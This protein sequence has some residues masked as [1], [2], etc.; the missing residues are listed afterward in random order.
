MVRQQKTNGTKDYSALN[1]ERVHG[2]GTG[3]G[4]NDE[5]ETIVNTTIGVLS[6]RPSE[7]HQSWT[8]YPS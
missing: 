2:N 4:G 8:V 6:R 7:I 3:H 1:R 5:Q